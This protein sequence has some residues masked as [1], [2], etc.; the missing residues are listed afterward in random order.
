M[1][2][3]L[4][5]LSFCFIA[6][7]TKTE[8]LDVVKGDPGPKGNDGTSFSCTGVQTENGYTFSCSDGNSYSLFNGYN[9]TNGN[10]AQ[11]CL[12]NDTEGGAEITCAN[13]TVA[14]Y[15]GTNGTNGNDGNTGATGPQG[16]PGSSSSVTISS[17]TSSSCTLVTGSTTYTKP[18]GSGMGLYTSSSCHS[19][20][21]YAEVQQGEAYIVAGTNKLAV[22]KSTGMNV[23]NF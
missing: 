21:K 19:S 5:L 11:A 12:V 17:Y 3:V 18:T 14:I 15:D 23:W 6:C 7:S 1:K 20:S 10:D 16:P 4:V 22:W 13:G 8:T 2:F 9:G